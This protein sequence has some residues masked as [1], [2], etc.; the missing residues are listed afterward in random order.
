MV[1]FL[2]IFNNGCELSLDSP[3]PT[4]VGPSLLAREEAT[5]GLSWRP[6]QTSPVE[7]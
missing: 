3:D 6:H 1:A 4:F 2:D 7:D 5:I